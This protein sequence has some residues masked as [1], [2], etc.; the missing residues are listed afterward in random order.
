MIP[1][2]ILIYEVDL[3]EISQLPH[4]TDVLQYDTKF[5][6]YTIKQTGM[7]KFSVNCRFK[8][9]LFEPPRLPEI[10]PEYIVKQET[11]A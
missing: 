11:T 2:S 8:Y 7:D 6:Y 5:G 4:G 9:F 1:V 3:N 10:N